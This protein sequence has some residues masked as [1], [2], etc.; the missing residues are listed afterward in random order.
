M[1]RRKHNKSIEVTKLSSLVADNLGIKGDVMFSG[2]LRVDGRIDGNVLCEPGTHGLLVLSDKG[3]I[4][5]SVRTY[6][7]VINGTISGDL[8]VEHFLELQANARVTGNITYRQLQLECGATIDG[9]LVCA[10]DAATVA[11]AA[12]ALPAVPRPVR[13]A[14]VVNMP[15]S[16]PVSAIGS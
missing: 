10:G 14:N 3:S 12:A 6:D 15:G 11:P 13:E 2:G 4:N 7:A 1:F 8:E 9:K 16:T 5:G